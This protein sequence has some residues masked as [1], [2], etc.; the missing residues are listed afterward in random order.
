MGPP[1][2]GSPVALAG[3]GAAM[4]V[5]TGGRPQRGEFWRLLT[6]RLIFFF[7]RSV[8]LTTAIR[9]KPIHMDPAC[10]L[11]PH[12]LICASISFYG[13]LFSFFLSNLIISTLILRGWGRALFYSNQI[14]P[15]MR[16]HGWAHTRGAGKSRPIHIGIAVA[17][18]KIGR[19][20]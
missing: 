4:A 1:G 9:K 3:V 18:V 10:L 11:P 8:G 16:E 5:C 13:C 19:Y 12:A 7:F 20:C 14:M 15:R 2:G 17:L 6:S